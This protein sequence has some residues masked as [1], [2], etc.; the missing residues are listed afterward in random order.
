MKRCRHQYIS[1]IVRVDRKVLAVGPSNSSSNTTHCKLLRVKVLMKQSLIH[2]TRLGFALG[3]V[4]RCGPLGSIDRLST[5]SRGETHPRVRGR[6]GCRDR[7]L[8]T[9][10]SIHPE[11]SIRTQRFVLGCFLKGMCGR[12]VTIGR[13]RR[14]VTVG[15]GGPLQRY[16]SVTA[17]VVHLQESQGASEKGWEERCVVGA[18]REQSGQKATRTVDARGS[19]QRGRSRGEGAKAL[20]FP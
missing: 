14:G 16:S 13:E 7:L 17:F 2:R 4:L 1:Q 20:L 18:Y 8:L 5:I 3:I 12:G 9:C 19:R 10:K 11:I 15:T 6:A